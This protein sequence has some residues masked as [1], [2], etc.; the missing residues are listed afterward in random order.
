MSVDHVDHI[1]LHFC[2]A[3][4]ALFFFSATPGHHVV[5]HYLF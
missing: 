4:R 3:F 5:R 2:S 1:F